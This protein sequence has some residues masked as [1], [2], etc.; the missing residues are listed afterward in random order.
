M[1]EINTVEKLKQCFGQI[2]PNTDSR[3]NI[4]PLMFVI[5]LIFSNLGDTQKPSLDAIRRNLK[6][7]CQQDIS[8]SSFWER[9][10][11]KRLTQFLNKAIIELLKQ[12]G[13][14][15]VGGGNLLER[16]N[17]TGILVID[18]SSFTL[19]DGSKDSFPGVS[20]TAGVKFHACFDILTGELY[21]FEITPSSTHD[22]KCFP[23]LKSLIGKLIIVD[24][25]DWD[26]NLLWQIKDI[27]GYF[28][29]RI[30]SNAVITVT[31]IIQ[32]RISQK[33]LD[34]SLFSI[35]FKHK[36]ALILELMVEKVCDKGTLCCRAVGFWNPC[37]KCYHW[38]ITNLTVAAKLI[39]PLYRMRWQIELI[40]K[41]C[42][43]SLNAER[44]TSNN[45]TI[46]ENLLL[47]SIVAHLASH[48]ILDIVIPQLTK[49]KQLAISVQRTAKIVVLLG[50]D[51]FKFLVIGSKK[52]ALIL[53][54]KIML[55]ANDL[56]DPNFRHRES[57][58]ARIMRLI[59][60]LS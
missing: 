51:F 22:R 3:A 31:K 49:V 40:F 7:L 27:G 9:L 50:A 46:I 24:L 2:I 45:S 16:L 8:R 20:T 52:Y 58:L 43:Q 6:N 17:I 30:K 19:W 53:I 15:L 42:K 37:D 25:G 28:L 14:S 47:S 21:W 39:Y 12:F 29:S 54:D 26:F 38:Y 60:G 4:S 32:G 33:Y 18:S 13:T 36:R 56:F 34:K 23:D 44:L 35:P 1:N 59:E 11:R 57:S 5:S 10:S 55:F 48:T 41:A